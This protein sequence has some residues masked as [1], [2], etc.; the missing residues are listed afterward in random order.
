MAG[1]DLD[2][3][4]RLLALVAE[5]LKVGGSTLLRNGFTAAGAVSLLGADITGNLECDG[6]KFNGTDASGNALNADGLKVGHSVLLRHGFITRRHGEAARRRHH[7]QPRMRRR[8]VPR[9]RTEA[10]IP[11]PS[12]TA[13]IVA[14]RAA[15]WRMTSTDAVTP[16]ATASPAATS[17]ATSKTCRAT[18]AA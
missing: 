1:G 6:A 15:L 12:R 13:R 8:G 17:A 16:I 9:T 7:R 5:R 4:A 11:P 2:V 3:N 14:R 10:G 18:L